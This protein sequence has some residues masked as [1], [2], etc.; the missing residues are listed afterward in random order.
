MT[1]LVCPFVTEANRSWTVPGVAPFTIVP[2][3]VTKPD[4]E[5]LLLNTA[6]ESVFK[7][8]MISVVKLVVEELLPNTSERRIE[9]LGPLMDSLNPPAP[10]HCVNKVNSYSVMAFAAKLKLNPVTSAADVTVVVTSELR[11]VITRR[12]SCVGIACY[13]T[14]Q[15][16]CNYT[17][18]EIT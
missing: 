8:V 18:S 12:S 4:R 3:I 6:V 11:R 15:I 13:I 16:A 17:G 7:A 9:P 14:R 10:E 2:R 5:P 1:R